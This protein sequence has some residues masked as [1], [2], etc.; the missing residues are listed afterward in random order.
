VHVLLQSAACCA[1]SAVA[2]ALTWQYMLE[3]QEGLSSCCCCR[4]TPHGRK[5]AAG[6]GASDTADVTEAQSQTLAIYAEP[7]LLL[8]W[9]QQLLLLPQQVVADV[10]LHPGLWLQ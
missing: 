5:S 7:A 10:L 1:T 6:A 8:P 3:D 2:D 4:L 9:Q